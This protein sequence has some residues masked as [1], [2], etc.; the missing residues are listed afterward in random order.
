M[1]GHINIEIKE[2]NDCL[3]ITKK[4][5]VLLLV[6][7][8][9]HWKLPIGYFLTDGLHT[10]QKAD[11]V[12]KSLIMLHSNQCKVIVLT[13]DSLSANLNMMKRLGCSYDAQSMK[14]TF[15]HPSDSSAEVA[16]FL[17]PSH[18]LRLVR[19]AFRGK[20]VSLF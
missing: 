19:N 5:F 6:C 11:L 7:I 14:T 10:D 2:N 16:I 9:K 17:D 18:M 3:P 15:P 13:F 12:K 1:Y 4:A 20:I 8:N